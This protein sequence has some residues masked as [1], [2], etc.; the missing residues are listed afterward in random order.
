MVY[1]GGGSCSPLVVSTPIE[2]TFNCEESTGVTT[3]ESFVSLLLVEESLQLLMIPTVN[4]KMAI[5]ISVLKR[6]SKLNCFIIKIYK[7]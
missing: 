3:V 7:R 2:S 4:N 6:F 1:L 5:T